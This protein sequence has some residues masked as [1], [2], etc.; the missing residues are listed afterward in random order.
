MALGL[1]GCSPS[2]AQVSAATPDAPDA[3]QYGAV[4]DDIPGNQETEDVCRAFSSREMVLRRISQGLLV[5]GGGSGLATIPADDP[6]VQQG[7]AI[8]AATAAV[9]ALGLE[10]W[11]E[12]EAAD[13]GRKCE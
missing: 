1:V 2:L 4:P 11:R 8:G 12:Q 3:P 5:L 9:I 10:A 7:L 13:Y 6:D